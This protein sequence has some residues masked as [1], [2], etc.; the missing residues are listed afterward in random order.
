MLQLKPSPQRNPD[1]QR[2][3]HSPSEAQS[4]RICLTDESKDQEVRG[5]GP[6]GPGTEVA[7]WPLP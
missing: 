5:N 7:T 3:R 2:Y 1:S 6:L 4:L